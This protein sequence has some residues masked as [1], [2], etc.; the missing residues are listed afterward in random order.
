M[1]TTRRLSLLSFIVLALSWVSSGTPITL[2]TDAGVSLFAKKC[3]VCHGKDGTGLPNWK[4]KGQP[5][6]TRSE[7]Q[8]SHTDEEITDTIKNGK[9]ESM[10]SF[11]DKLSDEDINALLLRV[12]MFKKEK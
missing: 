2:P 4:S 9:G 6:L 8:D 10:P 5:N 12:R 7:W 3:A 1:K 11:K